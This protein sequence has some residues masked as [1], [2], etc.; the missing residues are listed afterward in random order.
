M[1][2]SICVAENIHSIASDCK[3][4]S[5]PPLSDAL[6][7]MVGSAYDMLSKTDKATLEFLHLA[8]K[9]SLS[10]SLLKETFTSEITCDVASETLV[11]TLNAAKT[12]IERLLSLISKTKGTLSAHPK[13]TLVTITQQNS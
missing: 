6:S 8:K 4:S 13:V 11:G 7:S 1:Q 5:S 2:E 10:H 9:S 12:E 3:K